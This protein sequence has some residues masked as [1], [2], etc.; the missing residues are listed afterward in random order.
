MRITVV[1][2]NKSVA[3][4][5]AY[6]LEDAGHAVDQIADGAQA[7][8]ILRGDWGDLLI[9]DVTL[10]GLSGLEILRRLR[11]RGDAR[12]VIV[13]TA[14]S[15]THDRVAGLD[16]G[17]DDYLIKPFEMAELEARVRALS[18]RSERP[19]RTE[20]TFGPLRLDPGART[21]HAHDTA[22]DLPRRELALLEA[23]IRADGR[24]VSRADLIAQVYG[25]GADVEDSAVEAH[26]SRLRKRLRPLGCTIK[27][28]RGLGYRLT[29][30]A[31][32]P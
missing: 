9:L 2:D 5:I 24:I 4:G 26:I 8:A 31:E 22:L 25:T 7:D 12:P 14:L 32:R 10:P 23:L 1:E 19:I 28:Q 13:L 27:V 17:A 3:Q 11:D 6:R 15:D 20:L 21:A 18:R 29:A 16:A 30:E